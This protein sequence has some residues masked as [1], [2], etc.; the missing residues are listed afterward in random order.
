MGFEARAWSLA[1]T[2]LALTACK[3]A[4]PASIKQADGRLTFSTDDGSG[5]ERC[6]RSVYVYPDEPASADPIWHIEEVRRV[7]CVRTIDYGQVPE[8]F[9]TD[10]PSPRLQPGATYRVGVL[11]PGFNEV[12]GFV[13]K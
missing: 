1:L 12:L 2:C 4:A 11:G 5:R 3:I 8:G 10:G 7:A 9:A 6:I 13:A